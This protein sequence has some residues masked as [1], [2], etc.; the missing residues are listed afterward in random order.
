MPSPHSL[1]SSAPPPEPTQSEK[2]TLTT[3]Q[4]SSVPA[5]GYLCRWGSSVW[6]EEILVE[7]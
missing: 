1:S 3:E 5:D 7:A 4:V 6:C 2:Q